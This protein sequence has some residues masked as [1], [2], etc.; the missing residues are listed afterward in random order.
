MAKA[1]YRASGDER[2][3]QR[4]DHGAEQLREPVDGGTPEGDASA[5]EQAERDRWVDVPTRRVARDRHRGHQRQRVRDGHR[6]QA[7]R[8][9]RVVLVQLPC[10]S[11]ERKIVKRRSSEQHRMHALR[12]CT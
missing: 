11:D 2:E 8:R 5:H 4:R 6:E 9:C 7:A 1:N 10:K 12:A 3:Q